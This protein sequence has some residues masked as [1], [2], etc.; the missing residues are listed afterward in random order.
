M[1]FLKF[2][3][4][5]F[6]A[7]FNSAKRAFKKLTP[8]QQAALQHGAGIIDL[9][10][11]MIK[12]SPTAVRKEIAKKFP[13]LD[14]EKLEAGLFEIAHA[15]NL[16]AAHSSLDDV[17]IALQRH[18]GGLQGKRWA[19]ASNFAANVFAIFLSP[20]ETKVA[21]IVTLMEWVYQHFFKKAA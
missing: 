9:I 3:G 12:A 1:S 10:N 18:L 20:K 19:Q 21:A 6:S 13:D 7:L 11:K 15:F 4:K 14:A 17:I 8:E 5:I 16:A 2:F